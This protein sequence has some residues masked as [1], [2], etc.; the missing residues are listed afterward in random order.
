MPAMSEKRNE[1]YLDESVQIENI[2]IK[3][4]QNV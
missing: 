2:Y 4:E 3:T 1:D